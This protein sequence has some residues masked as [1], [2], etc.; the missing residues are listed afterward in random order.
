MFITVVT[1]VILQRKTMSEFCNVV[2]AY[3]LD[4]ENEKSKNLN[5]KFF[6]KSL[7][8]KKRFPPNLLK[9]KTNN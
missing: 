2:K 6:F 7:Q 9:T 8:M 4:N 3:I 5:A 1:S